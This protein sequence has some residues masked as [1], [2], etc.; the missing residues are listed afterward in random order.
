ML[1]L[2]EHLLSFGTRIPSM[3]K[4]DPKR[5]VR[6]RKMPTQRRSV[7]TVGFI[8]D[9]AARILEERGFDGY[10]TNAIAERAGISIGT[11]YQYFASKEAI[12]AALVARE[13]AHL[14]HELDLARET[15]N[16]TTGIRL[17]IAAAVAYQLK[18]PRLAE[19]LELAEK[20]LMLSDGQENVQKLAQDVIA[21]LLE[22]NE[23]YVAQ[24]ART[25]SRD[26]V[27]IAH[28][29]IDSAGRYGETDIEGL[30]QRVHYAISGYLDASTTCTIANKNVAGVL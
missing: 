3:E 14:C 15:R 23:V 9:A 6:P 4:L 8:L 29:I 17:A 12:T 30:C 28:G 10:T 19:Q 20:L 27:G 5:T 25:V 22:L 11:C 18:R 26:L 1:L 13:T 24:D 7:A 21:S 16:W 2:C